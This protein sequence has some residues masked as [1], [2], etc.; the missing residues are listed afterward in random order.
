MNLMLN[1]LNHLSTTILSAVLNSVAPA[2]AAALIIWLALRFM[3]RVNAATRHAVWWAA[4]ATVVVM[5][6]T[7]LPRSAHDS[8]PAVAARQVSA[9][10]VSAPMGFGAT[11][12]PETRTSPASKSKDAA[13]LVTITGPA[14]QMAGM[15]LRC[16]ARGMSLSFRTSDPQLSAPA[17]STSE[18][19]SRNRRTGCAL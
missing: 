10:Q 6:F 3:P 14:G 8:L 12:P 15:V 7:L 13:S 1:A 17:Q 11:P 2:L 19:S 16:L 5:P 18:L 9:P 4:L